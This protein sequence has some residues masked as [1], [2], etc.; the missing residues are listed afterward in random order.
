[1]KATKPLIAAILV[2]VLASAP[3]AQ[4]YPERPIRV[5]V[6]Y[7]PGGATDLAARFVADKMSSALA[8]CRT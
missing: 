5:V 7:S 2:S 4:A 6:G 3:G 8:A 1:M